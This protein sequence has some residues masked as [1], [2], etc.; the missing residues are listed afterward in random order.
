MVEHEIEVDED[1]EGKIMA[2]RLYRDGKLTT[3]Q[4]RDIL[5]RQLKQEKIFGYGSY[6]EFFNDYFRKQLVAVEDLNRIQ[7]IKD[8]RQR[9]E[10]RWNAP[11]KG[12]NYNM[13]QGQQM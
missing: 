5:L 8:A 6:E 12:Y 11:N 10:R 3:S 1:D 9:Y 13:M 7:Q 2:L 4:I